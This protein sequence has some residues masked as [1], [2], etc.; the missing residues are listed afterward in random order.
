MA[1]LGQAIQLESELLPSSLLYPVG[2]FSHLVALQE[3]SFTWRYDLH[4]I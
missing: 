4:A 1:S 3:C 2:H